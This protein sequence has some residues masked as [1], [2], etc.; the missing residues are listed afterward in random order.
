MYERS[1]ELWAP[2][3]LPACAVLQLDLLRPHIAELRRVFASRKAALC[4]ALREFLPG[5]SFT[6]PQGGYFVW[7]QLPRGV[8][9][10]QLLAEA[11]E[12]HGVA[13]TPGSRC[14]LHGSSSASSSSEADAAMARSIRLSFAFYDEDEIRLGV[15]RLSQALR[16]VC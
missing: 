12:H 5:C 10:E 13:F 11:T 14:F 2:S 9:G 6:E 15:Q 16:S 8:H 3:Y 7:V 1:T 4:A